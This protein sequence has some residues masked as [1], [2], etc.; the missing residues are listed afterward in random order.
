MKRVLKWLGLILA[1]GILAVAGFVA[2]LWLAPY[3]SFDPVVPSVT[4]VSTPERVAHGRRLA[5]SLCVACHENPE[6]KT[7]SG[8]LMAD[9]PPEFGT[10]YSK[11][12]TQHPTKGIGGWSDGEILGLLRTGIHPR[13]GQFVPPWMPR[14]NR[15][16][17]EDLE[18]IVAWLRSD[19]PI[20][21]ATDQTNIE[22]TP[23]LLSKFLMRVVMSPT[24]LPTQRINVP[25]ASNIVEFGR[26]V[27]NDRYS[28]Y[29]CHSADFKDQDDVH[30]ENSA[31]FYG[32]GMT[33]P[34]LVGRPVY[35]PN[36]TAHAK[37]GLGAWSESEFVSAMLTGVNK[38]GTPF[39]YPMVRH[40][41]LT[42]EELAGVFAY[43]RSIPIL[44]GTPA[45][46]P[47]Y[48]EASEPGPKGLYYNY[49]CAG[50]HGASGLGV[51]SLLKA[52]A[53]YPEDSVLADMIR[54]VS[55]YNPEAWMPEYHSVIPES[56]AIQLAG[57]VRKLCTSK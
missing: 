10:V 44:E 22:S 26:Y 15:M 8:K 7:T 50:C 19:D 3:P 20:V 21:A 45:T 1:V 41:M 9:M 29:G 11:N 34:D 31:G 35:V 40:N 43:L 39:R 42:T 23:T 14:F 49:G 52:N 4:V 37:N 55:R 24:D 47:D 38:N 36:L 25:P 57:Y 32:G 16:A 13:T 27:A 48:A 12:I 17:D 5:L 18:S 2:F 56:D 6:T 51:A 53:K 33:M 46:T 28:C 54:N 30:P